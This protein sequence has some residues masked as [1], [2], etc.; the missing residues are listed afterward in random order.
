MRSRSLLQHSTLG[1]IVA[2]LLMLTN[3]SIAQSLSAESTSYLLPTSYSASLNRSGVSS[4]IVAAATMPPSEDSSSIVTVQPPVVRRNNIRPASS[5]GVDVHVGVGGI[6]FDVAT[7]LSRKFNLRT[8]ADFF[9]Y[10]TSFQE[11]GADVTANLRFRSGHA[12]LDWFP[13]SGRFRLSP[14]LVYGNNNR[15]IATAL[16]PS[17]STVTLNGQDYVSSA[18]DPLHGSGSVD[19]RKVSPG[20]SLGFGNISPRTK[21]HFSVPIEAGFYYVGQPGLRVAFTGSACDP[22]QPPAIGCQS[23][24]QD[25]D[26]QHDLAAFVTRNNHNLSYASFFPV[27]SI[28]I[29]YR[30]GS[31]QGR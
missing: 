31:L 24:D 26:F 10:G 23:V 9:S 20:F 7:P 15:V 22:T 12:S 16:V 17:G 19:F 3:A 5:V 25:A 28:G 1:S 21:S 2:T 8:G 29:G 14:L 30:F 11:Q 13:F 27:F 18:T 6:G 4:S